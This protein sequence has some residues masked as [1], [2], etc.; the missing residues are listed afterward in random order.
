MN[1]KASTEAAIHKFIQKNCGP[2]NS[3]VPKRQNKKP[4]KKTESDVLHWARDN[5]FYLHVVEASS[6]DPLLG[7]KGMA[8][9]QAGLSDV[10]GN[11][12]TG[13][14]CWI[15]LKA[16]D[17]RSTLSELQR[18]FL[19]Q[20][21]EQNCFAVV[22]DT[23]DRLNQYWRGFCTLKT[24]TEKQKYLTDCLPKKSQ[25]IKPARDQFEEKYGF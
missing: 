18:R 2:Q 19:E 22:V 9:A 17:R 10:I 20:K 13:L 12:P 21:I 1:R 15:E 16:K 25:R 4:E 3:R 6:Y 14:S 5:G 23:V 11:T 24:P 8:K 7:R